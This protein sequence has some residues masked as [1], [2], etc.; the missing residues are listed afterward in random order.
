MGIEKQLNEYHERHL[1]TEDSLEA[2][3]QRIADGELAQRVETSSRKLRMTEALDSGEIA[4]LVSRQQYDILV[5]FFK[6]GKTPQ[7]IAADLHLEETN[8]YLQLRRA[9]IS[10]QGKL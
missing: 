10:L 8:V 1:T 5:K 7:E 2:H 6:Y 4:S 9:T 3:N